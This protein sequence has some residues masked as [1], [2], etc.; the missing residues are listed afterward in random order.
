MAATYN[1]NAETVMYAQV[2]LSEP[3]VIPAG[4]SVTLGYVLISEL[5]EDGGAASD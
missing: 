5:P 1:A 2:L 4:G 3:L